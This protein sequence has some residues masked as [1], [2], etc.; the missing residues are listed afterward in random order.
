ML[1]TLRK[2]GKPIFNFWFTNKIVITVLFY[3]IFIAELFFWGKLSDANFL[4]LNIWWIV[5]LFS[6]KY[7]SKINLFN[8]TFVFS[9]AF[10]FNLFGNDLITEKSA[11]WLFFFLLIFFIQHF[12]AKTINEKNISK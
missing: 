2:L 1:K 4:I 11:S 7:G 3:V 10:I 5:I 8:A 12:A 9:I 6:Y